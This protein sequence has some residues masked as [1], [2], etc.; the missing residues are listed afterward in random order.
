MDQ[1]SQNQSM[2]GMKPEGST[3]VSGVDGFMAPTKSNFNLDNLDTAEAS[4]DNQAPTPVVSEK[5][6][7]SKAKIWI[8][9]LAVL[10]VIAAAA[11]GYFYMQYS[12][13]KDDLSS[14]QKLNTQASTTKSEV[15]TLKQ[16]NADLQK[17]VNS[18]TEYIGSLLKVANQLKTTCGNACASLAIPA[19]PAGVV[20]P[21]PTSTAKPTAT[22]A[23]TATPKPTTTP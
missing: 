3:P 5:D 13:T 1:D 11:A 7:S 9:V 21:T 12:K 14:A 4:A 8:I 2:D 19:A 23:T 15:D 18:Q 22:P 17:T 20:T 10:F 16:Q 6:K